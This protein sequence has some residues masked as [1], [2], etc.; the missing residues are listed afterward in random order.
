MGVGEVKLLHVVSFYFRVGVS[1]AG[2]AVGS[3]FSPL[4]FCYFGLCTCNEE[5]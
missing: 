2:I 4:L 1:R 5:V 3:V